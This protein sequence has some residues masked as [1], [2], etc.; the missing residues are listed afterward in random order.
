MS[1]L[2]EADATDKKTW[3]Y[4]GDLLEIL[5]KAGMSSEEEDLLDTGVAVVPVFKIKKCA[6]RAR[7]FAAYMQDIDDATPAIKLSRGTQT[8]PRIRV[9]DEGT[10]KPPSGLP[11]GCYD[12]GWLREQRQ[13]R[14]LYVKKEL[15]VSSKRF[16]FLVGPFGKGKQMD[17]DEDL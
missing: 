6:W 2:K 14:P 10:S 13:N 12:E 17:D 1:L 8:L 3:K 7:P 16:T 5:T 15:K 4:Y 9:D 11:E